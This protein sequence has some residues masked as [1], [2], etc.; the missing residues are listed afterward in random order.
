MF[1][2][3]FLVGQGT[4]SDGHPDILIHIA[5]TTKEECMRRAIAFSRLFLSVLTDI[6]H[7]SA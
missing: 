3:Q 2:A 1:V 7:Y 6:G 4:F 5:G